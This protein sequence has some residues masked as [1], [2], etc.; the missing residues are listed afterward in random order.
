MGR[1]LSEVQTST[2]KTHN[3]GDLMHKVMIVNSI[4]LSN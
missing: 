3:S 2:Y 1:H 4:V